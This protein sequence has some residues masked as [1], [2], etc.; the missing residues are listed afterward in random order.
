MLLVNQ[1][2]VLCWWWCSPVNKKWIKSLI[3]QVWS[4]GH[5]V[6]DRNRRCCSCSKTFSSRCSSSSI[7]TSETNVW[8]EACPSWWK[9]KQTFNIFSQLPF[10]EQGK[11]L[12]GNDVSGALCLATPWPGLARTVF[13]D[14]KRYVDTYFSVYPGYYF[15]GDGALRDKD[16]YYQITGRMDDVI[17]VTGHRY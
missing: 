3:V 7:K 5:L 8:H 11:P 9:G 14:H 16:G 17:N 10:F 12:D 6:A 1:G 13:G 2:T 15:T 4:G